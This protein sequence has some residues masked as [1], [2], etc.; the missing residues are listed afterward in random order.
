MLDQKNVLKNLLWDKSLQIHLK[1]L[2]SKTIK[3]KAIVNLE[4]NGMGAYTRRFS[5]ILAGC[6]LTR[7]PTAYFCS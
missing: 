5:V 7:I 6:P 4:K 3:D 2:Y 1:L